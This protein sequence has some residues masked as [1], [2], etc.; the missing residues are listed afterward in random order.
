MIITDE[1]V[2][3][4]YRAWLDSFGA[5]SRE[6]IRRA[7]TAAVE[8]MGMAGTGLAHTTSQDGVLWY[9]RYP[10]RST[11]KVE[12]YD[13]RAADDLIIGYDF[14]RDG[15]TIARDEQPEVEVAFVRSWA[16]YAAADEAEGYTVVPHDSCDVSSALRSQWR[17][18]P[19]WH[20]VWP[21]GASWC[22][23]TEAEAL[24][25]AAELRQLRDEV[26]R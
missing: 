20:T 22:Y 2:D 10:E 18:G 11:I 14:D 7:V 24:D 1:L 6:M 17:N 9:P 4:A 8:H 25:R 13:V 5:N 15:Y 23:E 26:S 21:D 16:E 19:H 12:M 3:V